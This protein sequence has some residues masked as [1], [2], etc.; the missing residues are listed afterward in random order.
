[1]SMMRICGIVLGLLLAGGGHAAT[2]VDRLNQFFTQVSTL[3][4]RFVQE[5][6][7]EA[8]TVIQT[9]TGSMEL[10]RPGRFRWHYDTPYDQYIIADGKNLW[11]YDV[12]L[13]QVT[14]KPL[15]EA[16]TAA[17]VRLLTELRPLDG[18][19]IVRESKPQDGYEWVELKP[20]TEESEFQRIA[21][22]LDKNGVRRMDL[23][24]H[25]GQ[26]TVVRL[27]GLQTN[28]EVDASAFRFAVPKDV[29]VIGTAGDAPPPARGP[30][31]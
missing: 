30:R 31:K 21:F 8:G 3:K 4:G 16:I 29:D 12:E 25:F 27:E 5:V 24:D 11:I 10:S 7:D 17:P 26:K 18:D 2:N 19:F 1:M 6:F 28:V 14:V 23:Y 13:K 15:Q 20:K 9:S 22:A